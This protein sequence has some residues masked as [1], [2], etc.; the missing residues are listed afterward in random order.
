MSEMYT[1]TEMEEMA[2]AVVD[3]WTSRYDGEQ[4]TPNLT[5]F[6]AKSE[7]PMIVDPLVLGGP[8]EMQVFIKNMRADWTLMAMIGDI[9][10]GAPSARGRFLAAS[11]NRAL[12]VW[13]N[14]CGKGG[15]LWTRDI[16]PDG[17]LVDEIEE[18]DPGTFCV[19]PEERIQL[20]GAEG[21]GV[22][23]A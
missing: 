2:R 12:V 14:G 7:Q 9:A 4:L 5:L 11:T 18:F 3:Y 1:R 6:R 8:D 19:L 15:K 21:E 13:L 22:A 16:G 17:K 20:L 23:E 10:L